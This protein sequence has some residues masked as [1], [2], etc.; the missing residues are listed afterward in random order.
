MTYD[1]TPPLKRPERLRSLDAIR[2]FDMFW[3]I[4]GEEIFHGLA[5]V[6][7][8]RYHLY[9]NPTNWQLSLT[10]QVPFF[11]RLMVHLSNQLHHSVWNG[12]TF[13][14][15][16]FPLFIFI[17]GIAM[18]FAYARR[19]E[20]SGALTPL[21]KRRIYTRLLKRTLLLIIL[22]TVVNGALQFNGYENTRFASVLGR[23]GL[24]C[25]FAA[26]IHL[27][28]GTKGKIGWLAGLLLGYWALMTLVPVP[29]H[30]SGV[31]TP[32]GNLASYIDQHYLPGKLHRKIFDPEGLLGIIPATA[33]ALLG[34]LTGVFLSMQR[35]DLTGKKKLLTL[36]A[37]GAGLLVAGL[38][39]GQLFPINKTLW[40]SSF[41]LYA[42]GWSILLFALF[43][44]II[45]VAGF[46][47]WS[48]PFAWIGMN[49][50]LIYLM[51]HGM[52]DLL[53]SSKFFLGGMIK[54]LD[55]IWHRPILWTGVLLIQLWLLRILYE[56]KIFLKL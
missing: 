18:P 1:K 9:R 26:I 53:A 7:Q 38:L 32:E 37:A 51:A 55:P 31:L 36:I 39:W 2:G 16:I 52:V 17:A 6:V 19:P 45:D 3:I 8:Q 15:L 13:Y 29:G 20:A 23:I 11:Q 42:G 4:S 22:G 44:G 24:S 5:D 54:D 35:P 40:T 14:D 49:S 43:Y 47:K 34:V 21:D 10:D 56:R 48:Q 33:S 41:V 30:G 25:F 27:N 50:I 28:F 46:S 12:F